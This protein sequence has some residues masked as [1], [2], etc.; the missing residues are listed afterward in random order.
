MPIKEKWS[1]TTNSGFSSFFFVSGLSLRSITKGS[2]RVRVTIT[3]LL[4]TFLVFTNPARTLCNFSNAVS[5]PLKILVAAWKVFKITALA[6]LI[7][8][9]NPEPTTVKI[10]PNICTRV[11]TSRRVITINE[12]KINVRRV[13]TAPDGFNQV[14]R[15]PPN[16]SPINPPTGTTFSKKGSVANCIAIKEQRPTRNKTPEPRTNDQF[17]VSLPRINIQPITAVM[18]GTKKE[19]L[20]KIRTRPSAR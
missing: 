8:D 7:A 5:I 10:F 13:K 14:T 15:N 4:S 18:T 1:C 3:G 16:T 11:L 9:H 2:G 6:P 12:I 20:P 19:P 17:C